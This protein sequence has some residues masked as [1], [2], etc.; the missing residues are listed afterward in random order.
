MRPKPCP[1]CGAG[2]ILEQFRAQ[3]VGGKPVLRYWKH[4]ENECYLAGFEIAPEEI[5]CWNKRKERK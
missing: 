2:L 4:P 3:L 5:E 1:F